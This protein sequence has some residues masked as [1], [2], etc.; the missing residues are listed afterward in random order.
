MSC[1]GTTLAL[2]VY[3]GKAATVRCTAVICKV[4]EMI[5]NRSSFPQGAANRE[6][7]ADVP[8]CW[9]L[10][11]VVFPNTAQSKALRRA[12]RHETSAR[13]INLE[14]PAYFLKAKQGYTVRKMRKDK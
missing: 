10:Q 3:L 2:A 12:F 7:R 13:N 11:L 4:Q 9:Q 1:S 6:N 8:L 5:R 14:A